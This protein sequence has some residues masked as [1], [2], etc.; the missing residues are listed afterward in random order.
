ML[1]KNFL[2][3]HP[4]SRAFIAN[5]LDRTSTLISAQGESLLL[6]AGITFP[7]RASSAVLLIGE[8][9]SASTADIA[10]ALELPHQLATQRVELLL[11]LGIFNRIDDPQD[12]RRKI[13]KLTAKGAKELKLLNRALDDANH[14][15]EALFDEIECDLQNVLERTISA[16]LE[17]SVLDRVRSQQTTS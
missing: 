17:Q 4:K 5:L 12:K 10:A 9:G 2:Y 8:R 6:D 7:S 16:L 11:N 3:S 14:A 15:F 1:T 13:L